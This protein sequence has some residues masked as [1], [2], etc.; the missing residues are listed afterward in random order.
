MIRYKNPSVANAE[1]YDHISLKGN[2]DPIFFHV[3]FCKP[4]KNTYIIEHKEAESLQKTA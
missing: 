3:D 2:K 1:S 4:G